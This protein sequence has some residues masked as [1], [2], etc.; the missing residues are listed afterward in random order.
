MAVVKKAKVAFASVTKPEGHKN[1]KHMIGIYVTKDEKKALLKVANSAW[2]DGKSSKQE[3]PDHDPKK[4]FQKDETTGEI[5]FWVTANVKAKFPLELQN[6]DGGSFKKKHFASMGL[7][8]IINLEYGIYHYK[9][10]SGEGVARS[11]NTIQLLTYEKFV[12]G[13]ELNGQAVD[14]DEKDPDEEEAPKAKKDKKDKK[15]KKKKKNK[16]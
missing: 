3:D 15:K 16:E 1:G 6:V 9:N 13:S 7:G 8:S 4:W 14:M 12:G 10:D 5:I 2:K 11:A